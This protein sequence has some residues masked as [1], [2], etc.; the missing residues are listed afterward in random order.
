MIILC[1]DLLR[2]IIES[3]AECGGTWV[4]K[5]K[6]D[7][8]L[9]YAM[10]W[11][12]RVENGEEFVRITSNK[13]LRIE[14]QIFLHFHLIPSL[15]GFRSGSGSEETG[16]E[17]K[18]K[19]SCWSILCCLVD[20]MHRTKSSSSNNILKVFPFVFVCTRCAA[21]TYF[22]LAHDDNFSA[23]FFARLSQDVFS[24]AFLL[25]LGT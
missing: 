1:L 11:W 18:G 16:T 25:D 12:K 13:S 2:V 10:W 24:E 6:D 7:G 15:A 14:A 3:S 22:A 5:C 20:N 17:R 8:A 21:L 23:W 4:P 9:I 19:V